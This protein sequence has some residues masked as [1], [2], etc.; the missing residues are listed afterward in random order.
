MNGE[1]LGQW[2]TYL[3]SFRKNCLHGKFILGQKDFKVFG[4]SILLA[5]LNAM[6]KIDLLAQP[7]KN[8]NY[9]KKL[10]CK[11]ALAFLVPY[12]RVNFSINFIYFEYWI[13]FQKYGVLR[14]LKL[15]YYDKLQY[16]YL[17]SHNLII[18]FMKILTILKHK[19]IKIP[20]L[21]KTKFKLGCPNK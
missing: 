14:W 6:T 1:L 21:N 17:I 7:P 12:L 15:S 20:K 3:A 9:I 2:S 8:I 16:G 4:F 19:N 11:L 13:H 18:R 5:C 10:L